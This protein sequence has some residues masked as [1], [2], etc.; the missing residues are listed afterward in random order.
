[1]DDNII[2]HYSNEDTFILNIESYAD[3]YKITLTEIWQLVSRR[4]TQKRRCDCWLA[5]IYKAAIDWLISWLTVLWAVHWWRCSE[6]NQIPLWHCYTMKQV[7]FSVQ[8]DDDNQEIIE[9]LMNWLYSSSFYSSMLRGEW[10]IH[11]IY[12]CWILLLYKKCFTSLYSCQIT[13]QE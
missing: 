6:V 4:T 11:I 7:A 9:N 3:A 1:M 12:F 5:E 13:H 8:E 2:E 10:W